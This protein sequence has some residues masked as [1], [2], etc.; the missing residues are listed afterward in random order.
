MTIRYRQVEEAR[1]RRGRRGRHRAPLGQPLDA[2]NEV[3]TRIWPRL[4]E[5]EGLTLDALVERLCSEFE[6]DA[7]TA[8]TEAKVFLESPRQGTLAKEPRVAARRE[9]CDFAT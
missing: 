1:V 3:G 7:Q 6:V 8:A 5:G 2:L 4:C 9:A